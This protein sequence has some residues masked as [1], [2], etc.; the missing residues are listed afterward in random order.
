MN[1][2]R[3][4]E[5]VDKK[6][7]KEVRFVGFNKED[8]TI[9][10][11]PDIIK[12]VIY[13]RYSSDMQREESI[14]AQIRYCKE[15]IARNP[16]MVLVGVYYDEAISGKFD[17]RE[18]FQNMIADAR[19]HKFDQIMV[20][21]FSRFAR[22]QYDSVIY[23][24]KLRDIGIRVVS[25]TQKVDDTPEGQMTEAII[26]VLDQYY[27]ANLAEEVLKGM[28]E[29]A[30]KGLSTGGK[31]PLGY[32]RD[33]E[34]RY[35]IDPETAPIARKI[36][37][38]YVSGMG[39]YLIAN[40]LNNMGL[41]TQTGNVFHGRTVSD[42]LKNEKYNGTYIYTIGENEIRIPDNHEPI[43]PKSMW[44]QVQYLKMQRTKPRLTSDVIY[45]LTGKLY[46]GECHGS[47]SGGGHKKSRNGK[48]KNYYYVC[49]NKKYHNCKNKSINKDKIERYLCQHITRVLLTDKSIEDIANAFEAAVIEMSKQTTTVP[50]EKLE[51]EKLSLNKKIAKLLELYLEDD[52]VMPK[53]TLQKKTN[54]YKQQLKGIEK[55][56]ASAKVNFDNVMKKEDAINFL[57]HMRNSF[58]ESNKALVKSLIDTFVEKVVVYKD[59]VDIT[60]K[61]D[62]NKD[63]HLPSINAEL[64]NQPYPNSSASEGANER[65]ARPNPRLEPLFIKLATSRRLI[66][67]V[68]I[69]DLN[70]L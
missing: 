7:L 2:I 38:L 67:K 15:E 31:P 22:N 26:E 13:A 52:S 48:K 54:E 60:F 62:I 16:N 42:I 43:I 8:K 28:R 41:R 68:D 56:I 10:D 27:S 69:S 19:E 47:Y 55:Q 29:N 61:V 46:C 24:K 40:T 50:L 18:D 6:E 63:A 44:E 66:H 49:N 32:S 33:S 45:S 34:G 3:Y 58:D 36:F 57:T 17:D 5:I 35:I 20:H 23:K 51:K 9:L 14:D 21:K 53:E 1:D 37:D 65:F 11:V 64:T 59:K 4:I 39:T 70:L 30:L 12:V 25:A